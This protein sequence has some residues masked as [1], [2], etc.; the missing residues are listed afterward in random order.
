MAFN[1]AKLYSG[2]ALSFDGVNDFANVVYSDTIGSVWTWS[3][4]IEADALSGYQAIFGGT[5]GANNGLIVLKNNQLNIYTNTDNLFSYILETGKKYHVALSQS[6]S[7]VS[8]FI[9][10][11]LVDSVSLSVTLEAGGGSYYIGR[12]PYS[13]IEFFNGKMSGVKCIQHRPNRRTSGRPI[14]QPRAGGSYW[15]G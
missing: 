15:S 9:N 11:V 3:S 8:A 4:I 14:Q 5:F 2:K 7:S 1:R 10:G 13:A 12:N 6:G